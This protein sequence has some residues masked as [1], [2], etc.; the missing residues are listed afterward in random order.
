MTPLLL[1]NLRKGEFNGKMTTEG[2]IISYSKSIRDFFLVFILR[3]GMEKQ[4]RALELILVTSFVIHQKCQSGLKM[5]PSCSSIC[6]E[7][8]LENLHIPSLSNLN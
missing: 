6:F 7:S 5:I 4:E 1:K 8:Q 3:L 2:V